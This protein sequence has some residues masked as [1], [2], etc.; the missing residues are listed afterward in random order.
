MAD[1]KH[2]LLGVLTDFEAQYDSAKFRLRKRLGLGQICI[3]PYLGH[4]TTNTIYL[5]GRVLHDKGITSA[6]EDDSTWRNLLNMYKRY[7]SSEI[8]RARV[9]ARFG[10]L[11]QEVT[12]DDEG[13]F[14]LEF[15][16]FTLP[17]VDDMWYD[18]EL[19][20]LD[21][22]GK[23]Q[24]PTEPQ[25]VKATGKVI[26]P[27]PDAEF[28]IISDV[29]DTVLRTDVVNLTA[30]ARNTF[31]KN[32]R[33]RL[34]FEGAAAF[35]DALRRGKGKT[36]NPIY[37]VTS[38]AWNL[39]DLIVDFFVVRSI[40]LGPLF[41]VNLGLT[42]DHFLTPGHHQHKLS[43]IQTLLD[44]HPTLPFILIGDSGQKDPEIYLEAIQNNP[45][46]ILAVYIR[47]VTHQR[48]SAQVQLLIEKA[49]NLGVEMLMVSD[50]FA[51]AQ[52][53]ADKGFITADRLALVLK[54]RD[55]DKQAPTPL[56]QA[57]LPE[58]MIE[59]KKSETPDA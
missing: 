46:R 51:A 47:D 11:V 53:A 13:H 21:Y 6:M 29:D 42:E 43:A 37:Y 58:Q 3:V 34:P 40:P 55:E 26:V 14:H 22:P 23:S 52:N 57:V 41:M 36:Y 32:S 45:G 1:W 30:M 9:Q 16:G 18:I 2:A 25:E 7:Q 24:N 49:G 17:K 27:S 33:T 38:S 28:G 39:Y 59:A 5:R 31:L 10:D 15:S 12:A 19:E 44:S 4:G 20:L 50:T 35:Y 54:E 48:R 8:P 56:E